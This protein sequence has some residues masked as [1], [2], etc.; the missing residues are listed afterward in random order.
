MLTLPVPVENG[1]TRTHLAARALRLNCVTENYS[2][3]WNDV[4]PRLLK[5]S[6]SLIE[7]RISA[8]PAATA[9]WFRACAL[10]N[11]F[12]RRWAIVEIDALAALELKLTVE[13]LCAI[14]RVQ[15]PVLRSYER[16]TWYDRR[17]R[18]AFTTNSGL[19]GIGLARKDFEIWQSALKSGDTLPKD[20]DTQGLE[21]PFDV[22]DRE[23]DMRTAYAYFAEKLGKPAS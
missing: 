3:L 1:A 8:W 5:T 13:E 20:F 23:D 18:I 21:P 7:S 12:E 22:R 15:F 14:Y 2:D 11:H 4:W 19:P 9:K 10:R 17:G 6:S 16:T